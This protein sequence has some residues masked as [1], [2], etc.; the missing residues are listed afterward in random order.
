MTTYQLQLVISIIHE[1]Y[2]GELNM[3]EMSSS[4]QEFNHKTF[5][6]LRAVVVSVSGL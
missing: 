1:L 5:V 6:E 2:T 4:V 3:C